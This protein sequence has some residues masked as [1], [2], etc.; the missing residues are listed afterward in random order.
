VGPDLLPVNKSDAVRSF[1]GNYYIMV[2]TPAVKASIAFL[3]RPAR[4]NGDIPA[5]GRGDTPVLAFESD[6]RFS[7]SHQ[8]SSLKKAFHVFPNGERGGSAS[9]T[10][11]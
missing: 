1:V 9:R 3:T 5:S 4:E 6:C 7:P 8:P 2:E 11:G 10:R